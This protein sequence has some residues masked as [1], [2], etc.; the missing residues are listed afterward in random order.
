[1]IRS[2]IVS[3]T[4]SA[5]STYCILVAPLLIENNLDVLVDRILVV[6]V[7]EKTQLKRAMLRDN[8]SE[9]EIKAIPKR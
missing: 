6:D 3:Q 7:H 2:N 5:A 8:N 1:M 4:K 9:E